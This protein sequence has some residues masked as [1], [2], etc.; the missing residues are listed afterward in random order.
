MSCRI[1]IDGNVHNYVFSFQNYLYTYIRDILGSDFGTSLTIIFD[2]VHR[3]I[4]IR[5]YI[6]IKKI[7]V[8]LIITSDITS[9]TQI[10]K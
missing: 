2:L 3:F 10:H 4:S 6:G 5:C 9:L 7:I 8:Y 1:F